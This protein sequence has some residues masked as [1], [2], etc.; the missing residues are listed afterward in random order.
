M[1]IDPPALHIILLPGEL[2]AKAALPSAVQGAPVTSANK[3]S[4]TY[5]SGPEQEQRRRLRRWNGCSGCEIQGCRRTRRRA[6]SQG[7]GVER[8]RAGAT[9]L[10]CNKSAV[11][12]LGERLHLRIE[13]ELKEYI[14]SGKLHDW[15]IAQW[16]RWH[17]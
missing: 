4:E 6:E 5:Q 13:R 1:P 10:C 15:I 12:E 14:V 16:A 8:R 11:A 2:N 9:C 7:G 17:S 3:R